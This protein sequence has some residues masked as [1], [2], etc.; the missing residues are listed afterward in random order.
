M[1]CRDRRWHLLGPRI[2]GTSEILD[3]PGTRFYTVVRNQADAS[4]A[5]AR[6]RKAGSDFVKVYSVLPR[7]GYFAIAQESQRQ[8]LPFA[9]HVP[10]TVTVAETS[11]AGQRSIEHM[12]GML[13][14]VSSAEEEL[15]KQLAPLA[16]ADIFAARNAFERIELQSTK[17]YSSAKAAQLFSHLVRNRTW[18][19]PTLVVLRS[20]AFMDG[21]EFV[22]DPRLRYMTA[23]ARKRWTGQGDPELERRAG[24]RAID[25]ALYQKRLELVGAMQRA[26]VG[27]LAGT[28]M[29]NPY[30]FPGFSLHDE[31][32]LL[33]AAGLTPMQALQTATLNPARYFGKEQEFGTIG[34]GKR[35]ELVLLDADPLSDIRNTQ[36][37]AAVV[38]AGRLLDRPQLTSML[39]TVE[40]AAAGR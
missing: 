4:T 23:A 6:A 18:Q 3:G 16:H 31:L 26:G 35:A 14:A 20:M 34:V 9:G 25:K 29:T 13:L 7:A 1:A 38:V 10:L 8:G 2:L 11:D 37:I 22:K 27:I 19:C 24:E 30:V 15:R 5:V 21:A 17:S 12:T 28:D 40:A 36:R 32:V 39:Q 33:V